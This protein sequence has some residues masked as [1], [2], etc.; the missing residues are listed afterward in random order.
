[1]KQV[2][3]MLIMVILF[4][5]ACLAQQSQSTIDIEQYKKSKKYSFTEHAY[6]AGKHTYRIVNIKPLGPSDT[7]CISAIILDKRKFVLFDVNAA[8][9]PYGMI[10]PANQPIRD[11]FI[12]LKASS[13]DGKLFLMLPSGKL[14]T[15]P[16]ASVI[17]DTVGKCVYCVWDNDKTFRLTVFDYK[18]LRLV[19]NTVAIAEP[20]QWFTDGFSY[21]FSATDG[22]YYTIDFMQKTVTKGEKPASGLTAISYVADLDKIDR[23]KCCSGEVMK[24]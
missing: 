21:G 15:V 10:V 16:G 20:K 12:V 17:A 23:T 11:G 13:Y 14:V 2:V 1:M 5:V 3:S 19:F 7:A 4:V 8:A 6:T 24:K 18:N 9:G 22:A